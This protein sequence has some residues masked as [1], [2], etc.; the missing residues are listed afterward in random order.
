MRINLVHKIA[1]FFLVILM[2]TVDQHVTI[3][4]QGVF[5]NSITADMVPHTS[6]IPTGS[7]SYPENTFLGETQFNDHLQPAI[8]I[9]FLINGEYSAS[10]CDPQPFWLPPKGNYQ[11]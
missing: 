5:A 8:R 9:V 7:D 6:D 1:V 3:V 2:G 11:G 10:L 4:S